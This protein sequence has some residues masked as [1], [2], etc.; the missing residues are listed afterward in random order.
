M[1]DFVLLLLLKDS[2]EL[3]KRFMLE[4]TSAAEEILGR[5]RKIKQPWVTEK[6]LKM[7]DRRREIKKRRLEEVD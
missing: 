7:C 2:D 6:A 1:E 3:E 4:L 5:E